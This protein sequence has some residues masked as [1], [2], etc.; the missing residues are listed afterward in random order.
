MLARFMF[1]G[2]KW[3]LHHLD[4]VLLRLSHG[5]SIKSWCAFS[6]LLLCQLMTKSFV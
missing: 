1:E 3:G 6:S 5:F 2:T 4:W